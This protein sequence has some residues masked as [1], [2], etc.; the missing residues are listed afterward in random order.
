MTEG[1]R[2]AEA[3]AGA[4]PSKRAQPAGGRLA[5]NPKRVREL[6]P[7]AVQKGPIIYWWVGQPGQCKQLEWEAERGRLTMLRRIHLRTPRMS[8]A[9]TADGSPNALLLWVQDVPRPA[10][11]G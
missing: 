1:K 5:V 9:K 4:G 6:R 10:R 3:E 11:G 8:V 2:K 7:G